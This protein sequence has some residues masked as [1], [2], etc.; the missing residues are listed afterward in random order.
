MFSFSSS[1]R[2]S[3]SNISKMS[4]FLI[5][6][7]FHDMIYETADWGSFSLYVAMLLP[8]GTES[9]FLFLAGRL[10]SLN[11]WSLRR[12][13]K[14]DSTFHQDFPFVDQEVP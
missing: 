1:S 6:E 2:R 13:V 3:Y 11:L 4:S 9:C 8:G 14:A 5:S 10:D 12:I 7:R